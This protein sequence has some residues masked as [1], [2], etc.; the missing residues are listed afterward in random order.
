MQRFRVDLDSNAILEAF[1]ADLEET[2]GGAEPL[3]LPALRFEGDAGVEW[4]FGESPYAE[5]RT[6]ALGAGGVATGDPPPDPLAAVTRF[7]RAAS[8]EVAALCELPGPRAHAELWRLAAEGRLRPVRV[9]TGF[10][11]ELA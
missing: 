10:L 3:T 2:R 11:W 9:L 7:G 5:W 6:A 4:V 8:V 1:G